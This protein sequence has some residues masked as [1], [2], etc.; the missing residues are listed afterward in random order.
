MA[1]KESKK[2]QAPSPT[3][4]RSSPSVEEK[5]AQHSETKSESE[6]HDESSSNSIPN[7]KLV[8]PHDSRSPYQK[9][10]SALLEGTNQTENIVE[11][12]RAEVDAIKIHRQ[13]GSAST[14][15]PPPTPSN[16]AVLETCPGAP[17]KK[18][19]YPPRYY[20]SGSITDSDSEADYLFDRW[21]NKRENVIRK[22]KSTDLA[23]ERRRDGT[24]TPNSPSP[25]RVGF[26]IEELE[27]MSAKLEEMSQKI[28]DE[29]KNAKFDRSQR[30]AFRNSG[31]RN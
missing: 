24:T 10:M 30:K 25:L 9:R 20:S 18:K 11:L 16:L 5:R 14:L 31:T 1:P 6:A 15:A 23:N 29:I 8:L 27:K 4:A 21:A 13:Q 3:S 28:D 26:D 19:T 22:K 12:L 17:R 7:K 2:E